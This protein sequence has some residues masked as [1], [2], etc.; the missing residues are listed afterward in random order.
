MTG[1]LKR[2]LSEGFVDEL[3]EQL[4]VGFGELGAEAVVQHVDDLRERDLLFGLA[5]TDVGGGTERHGFGDAEQDL[6][7]VD[8]VES[9]VPERDVAFQVERR[10]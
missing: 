2:R 10:R 4:L 3:V 5:G 6:A 9:V 7:F 1:M 8:L